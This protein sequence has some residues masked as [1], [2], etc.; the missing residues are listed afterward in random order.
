VGISGRWVGGVRQSYTGA[1]KWGTG[2]NP[3]HEVRDQ[4]RGRVVGAKSVP[5]PPT[6]DDVLVVGP[7]M[8]S[9][10]LDYLCEDYYPEG[11]YEG[12]YYRYQAERPRWDEVTPQFRGYSNSPAMGEQPPWGVYGNNDPDDLFPLPGP[13]GGMQTWLDTEHGERIERQTAVSVFTRRVTGGW[14]SKQRGP[15]AVPESQDVTGNPTAQWAINTA[16]VQGPG[17][18]SLDNERARSRRTDDPRS[19]ITS[20]TAGMAEKAYGASF[21][22]GGGPGTPDMSPFQQSSGYMRPWVSRTAA[23]PPFEAHQYNEM[24]GRVP[25]ARTIPSDPYQGDPEFDAGQAD[26]VTGWW[27]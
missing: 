3:I 22:M 15:V 9:R 7:A 23:L 24:E 25:I 6:G 1:A 11:R 16:A 5:Y 8:V 4:G 20:R 12:E 26:I 19:P 10:D 21:R 13:T 14:M 2:Y 18:K 27:Y 17:L